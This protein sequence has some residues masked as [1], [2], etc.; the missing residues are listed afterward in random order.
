MLRG[1][2]E[3]AVTV[4]HMLAIKAG[5][6]AFPSVDRLMSLC[7]RCHN[8]K[9]A[10]TDRGSAHVQEET[11]GRRMK[12]FDVH[13]NPSFP[14]DNWHSGVPPIMREAG[15]LDRRGAREILSLRDSATTKDQA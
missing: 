9:T 14:A 3:S 6:D 15:R 4:D 7:G 11:F 12:G 13:G 5:G 1:H 8:E 10:A 2:Y